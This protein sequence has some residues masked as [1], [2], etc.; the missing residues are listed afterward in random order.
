MS[1]LSE[2]QITRAVL[3]H[4]RSLAVPGT[5]VAS[6][7]NM[8]AIGQYGLTKGLPDLI[9]IGGPVLK[10][11]AGFIELKTVAGKLRPEQITI[12]NILTLNGNPYAVCHG[13]DAPIRQLELW[14]VVRP[15]SPA[16]EAA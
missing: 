8:G 14:G 15:S 4:W 2:K 3:A 10:D 13:R 12:G 7:P 9:V 16:L 6:I 1:A 11:R 5:L